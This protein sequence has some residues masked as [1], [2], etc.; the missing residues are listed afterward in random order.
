MIPNNLVSDTQS[1]IMRSVMFRV[2]TPLACSFVLSPVLVAWFF[3]C[4]HSGTSSRTWTTAFWIA[5]R[6]GQPLTTCTGRH[7][8]W[9][10]A[11]RSGISRAIPG[12]ILIVV[13]LL[14]WVMW[15]IFRLFF[16]AFFVM[17]AFRF[18]YLLFYLVVILGFGGCLDLILGNVDSLGKEEQLIG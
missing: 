8:Y 9:L 15:Y 12:L 4:F 14:L 2:R 6:P 10:R 3:W 7:V 17:V 18:W 11:N 1:W 16:F 5:W 13:C